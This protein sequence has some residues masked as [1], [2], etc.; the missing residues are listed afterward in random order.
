MMCSWWVTSQNGDGRQ[1]QE[2]R[3]G[4]IF[5]AVESEGRIGRVSEA[6]E[7]VPWSAS[8][9]VHILRTPKTPIAM[10]QRQ[11]TVHRTHNKVRHRCGQIM[12]H[13]RDQACSVTSA[14]SL[15]C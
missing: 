3:E 8:C 12:G 7:S 5:G 14:T 10:Q 1:R 15:P 6:G 2:T 13:Y 4:D 11:N 9:H